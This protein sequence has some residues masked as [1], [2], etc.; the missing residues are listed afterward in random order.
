MKTLLLLLFLAVSTY[1]NANNATA[2]GEPDNLSMCTDTTT[3][4]F[5]LTVNNAA[6]L[7][8][9]NPADYTI[10]YHTTQADA[11]AG[12]NAISNATSYCIPIGNQTIYLRKQTNAGGAF[13]VF[14]FT[15]AVNA[16]F[17]SAL[18]LSQMVQCDDNGD[19]FVIF[20]LVE[21]AYLV[22]DEILS[23]YP[24]IAD[25]HAQTNEIMNP[26][27]YSLA[28][29]VNSD[30]NIIVRQEIVGEC[31]TLIPLPIIAL[32]SCDVANMCNTAHSLCDA[33]GVPVSNTIN[34]EEA[35]PFYYACLATTPNPVWFYIPI[36]VGGELRLKIEQNTMVDFTGNSINA[37]YI[38]FGPFTD[39]VTPCSDGILMGNNINACSYVGEN[40]EYPIVDNV[41]P[42]EFYLMMVINLYNTPG[43]IRVTEMPAST[44]E[45]DCRGIRMNAFLDVNTNGVKD[46]GEQNFPLG[47]FSYVLNDDTVVRN[48]FSAIG[49]YNIYD[50]VPTNSYDI[51]F[52]IDP[53]YAAN[54]SLATSS[55]ADVTIPPAGGM[56]EYTFPVSI[57]Q[58]YFDATIVLIPTGPP[59]PGF[60]YTYK[61]MYT[62]L[63]NET[64]PAG[65]VTFVR[66]PLLS[67]IVSISQPGTVPTST[68]F[69]YDYVDLLPFEEREIM[70]TVTVPTLP[71]VTLGEELTSSATIFPIVGDAMPLNNT[72]ANSEKIVGSFDPNDK[73]ESRGSQILFSDFTADDY[74]YYTIRFENTGSAPAININVT[75][76]LDSSLDASS[77][78]MVSASHDYILDRIGNEVSWKFDNVLLPFT[79]AD[80]VGS[81]GY[82]TFK[83]KPNAGY[84]IGTIVPNTAFIYFDFNPAIVTNTFTSE[85]VAQLATA[86]FNS[87]NISVWPNPA[88]NLV[89]IS[90]GDT[91]Q[92][93]DATLFDLVGKPVL[94]SE[95]VVNGSMQL[96]VSGI[97]SGIYL[98]EL[99]AAGKGKIVRKLVIE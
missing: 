57:V 33:L 73:M 42:G 18:V 37:D 69:S 54:Y 29:G 71:T 40:I 27:A 6:V 62:N 72:Y 20:N 13:E 10:S 92:L 75:D 63:G 19:G 30:T 64:I 98:L 21:G 66:D 5:D 87:S 99:N 53:D 74:L 96:D 47:Q 28:A 76:T 38:I 93:S 22:D 1:T 41:Q 70:I 55:F 4:C 15:I 89:M 39:P 50:V 91:D 88:N 59:V 11:A 2:A 84:D 16:A 85:F 58:S 77:L 78:R 95:T 43:Y 94:R 49:E 36:S 56:A 86:E 51:S 12:A 67:D 35:Q 44:A 68:G 9:A 79:D 32:P 46:V 82:I 34:I 80:P 83:I 97:S 25:A 7:D 52:T 31:D 23:F 24:T 17:G 14:D 3:G 8:G 26:T 48:G 61:L 81:H 65:S 60:S 45:I 90:M